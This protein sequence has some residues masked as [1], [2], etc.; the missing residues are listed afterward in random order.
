MR[1]KAAV[2]STK[3]PN[4]HQAGIQGIGSTINTQFKGRKNK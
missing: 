2:H 1:K 4:E 3:F